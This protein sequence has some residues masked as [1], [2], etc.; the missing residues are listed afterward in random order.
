MASRKCNGRSQWLIFQWLGGGS[1]CAMPWPIRFESEESGA[2]SGPSTSA[3]LS[4]FLIPLGRAWNCRWQAMGKRVCGKT[5]QI[6]STLCEAA[7][8][9]AVGWDIPTLIQATCHFSSLLHRISTSIS[10][11]FKEWE[12]KVRCSRSALFTLILFLQF[13]SNCCHFLA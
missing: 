1:G 4:P 12:Q 8:W 7:W 6:G 11:Q 3:P 10:Q 13:L 5:I 2:R 9:G